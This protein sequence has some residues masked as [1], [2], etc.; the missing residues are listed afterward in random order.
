[1]YR[2]VSFK[3]NDNGQGIIVHRTW[4]AQGVPIIEEIEHNLHTF[5]Q[6]DR[7]TK[8]KSIFDTNLTQTFFKNRQARNGFLKKYPD[9]KFFECLK[10][11]SEFLISRYLD[12]NEDKDFAKFPLRTHFIDIEISVESSFPEPK[13]AAFPINLISLYD[14]IEKQYYSWAMGDIKKEHPNTK[15][16]QFKTEEELLQNFLQHQNNT[17]VPDVYSG[18]NVLK[19]DIPYLYNRLKLLFD[20][21]TA[22]CLSPEQNTF[23]TDRFDSMGREYQRVFLAGISTL[24]YLILYRD[25]FLHRSPTNYKLG[26]VCEHEIGAGK[27]PFSG[28]SFKDQWTNHFDEYL[29]YNVRDVSLL[30]E[31]DNKMKLLDLA[32]RICNICL[33]PYEQIYPSIPYLTNALTV[34]T[35]KTTKKIF[36]SVVDEDNEK[37]PY[38]GAFVMEPIPAFYNRGIITIDLNSLY[39]NTIIACNI[40]PETKIG[41]IQDS[42]NGRELLLTDRRRI[43]LSDVQLNK[44]LETKA[45]MSKNNTLYLKSTTKIGIIPQFLRH[46]YSERIKNKKELK[47][48]KHELAELDKTTNPGKAAILKDDIARGETLDIAFKAF[49]NSIYGMFGTEFSP[50]FD[51][52]SAASITLTDQYIIKSVII[53]INDKFKKEYG[54][55]NTVLG[56]DTDGL[57][58]NVAPLL[59]KYLEENKKDIKKLT[60]HDILQITKWA[61]EFVEKE[62]NP[63]CQEITK[64][65][66][67]TTDADRIEFKRE[68]FALH[69]AYF[70]KKHYFL[71]IL[72]DSGITQNKFK[73]TG[74]E[75]KKNEFP[76]KVKGILQEVYERTCKEYWSEQDLQKYLSEKWENFTTLSFEDIALYRGY[77]TGK[78]SMNFLKMAKG[79]SIGSKAST[80]FNQLIEKFALKEK[81]ELISVGDK[82]RLAYVQP[83]EY[84]INVLGF[85]DEFPNEFK[86]LFIPDYS[87][88]FEKMVLNPLSEFT[89]LLHFKHFD[90]RKA[91]QT[92]I[93]QM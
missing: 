16:F 15:V 73:Y 81:Y 38:E 79:A 91:Q 51:I 85:K 53:Y 24:D 36:P 93:F 89:K 63:F 83:N 69:G 9:L 11:E 87:L 71:H 17:L 3:N 4:N 28:K 70:S 56:V 84:G 45:T 86:Q 82:I 8:F 68:V 13:F 18:W 29:D 65:G 49:L 26:S 2:N 72:D 75:V 46:F 44:A 33:V 21:Q 31:L 20:S 40:S 37:T 67:H 12:Q 54:V 22:S 14:T 39:P 6:V 47:K 52:D 64:T 78:D 66:I 30:V 19:F 59:N 32:R 74:M 48:L 55:D 42:G 92:D 61:D 5:H 7:P 35:R 57:S 23:I 80:Y 1:M 77:N 25:K 41:Q 58:F 62:L 90:P 88:M 60:R 34:F 50:I 27:M 76:K 10:P 43:P